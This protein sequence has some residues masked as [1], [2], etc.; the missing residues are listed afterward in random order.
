FSYGGEAGI[1]RPKD[2]DALSDAE[3]ADYLFHRKNPRGA[4]RELWNHALG[5]RRWFG[6]ERDTVSYQ[7]AATWKL[8]DGGPEGEG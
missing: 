4:H 5:C 3:W 1:V 6:A 8:S 2:P 7:F